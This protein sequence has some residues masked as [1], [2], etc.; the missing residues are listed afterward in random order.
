MSHSIVINDEWKEITDTK[1]VIDNEWKD[2]NI[3]QAVVD[4]E[5]KN[6]YTK[7]A[8][9]W[10]ANN[11]HADVV[12]S[13]SDLTAGWDG[14]DHVFGQV[15]ATLGKNSG[16]WYFEVS[17]V[18]SPVIYANCSVGVQNGDESLSV[19]IGDTVDGWGYMR[20]A[21]FYNSSLTYPDDSPT[22]GNDDV[23]MIAVDMDSGY[24]WFGK[25]GV[26]LPVSASSPNPATGTDPH[27]TNLTDT[28]YP[29]FCPYHTSWYGTAHF[30]SS[31]MDYTI[32]SGF[33]AWE[34]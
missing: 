14:A 21:R 4:N 13:D 24:I 26:W 20:N 25:N 1:I 33:S 7:E 3:I 10:D 5:W 2:V 18:V 17:I 16:K 34:V 6:V 29:A 22:F 23:I 31:D 15:L 11:K 27:Y 12:L 9:L 28:I 19:Y 8:V 32:P 30:K